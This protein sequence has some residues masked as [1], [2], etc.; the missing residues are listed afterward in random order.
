MPDK[1]DQ[2]LWDQVAKTVTPLGETPPNDE[3]PSNTI[4]FKE[5]IKDIK[6]PKQKKKKKSYTY[7][8]V[9]DLHGKTKTNAYN[10]L[11]KQ[12]AIYKLRGLTTVLVITGKGSAHGRKKTGALKRK[13]PLWLGTSAFKS[14]VRGVS[15]ARQSDGGEGAIYVHLR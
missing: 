8:A 6:V 7:Q 2:K 14:I 1:D 12:L 13:V 15:S 9:I 10:H 5:A 4:S 3:Q 11:E